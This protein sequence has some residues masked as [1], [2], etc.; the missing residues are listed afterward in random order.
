MS[1]E[2]VCNVIDTI[3]EKVG[4]VICFAFLIIMFIQVMEVILRYVFNRPTI[5]AWDV[6]GMIFSGTA[7]LAGAFVY[8]HDSHVRMDILYSRI[9]PKRRLILDIIGFPLLFLIFLVIM[10]QGGK[11]ALW[12]WKHDQRAT[13]YFAPVL[14]P[15]KSALPLAGFLM[16]LQSVSK[17][18]HAIK[19][20]RTS[21][22]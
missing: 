3:N 13:S 8:L 12:A 18:L 5:W 17:F 14:W 15:V 6:N 4:R 22:T 20:L 2:R 1:V 16:L 11:M 10:W 7:M 21:K 9:K 19:S